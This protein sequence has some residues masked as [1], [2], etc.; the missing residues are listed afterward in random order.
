MTL[1]LTQDY[2]FWSKVESTARSLAVL[3]VLA[4]DMAE[5][6]KAIATHDV[7]RVLIDL[8]HPDYLPLIQLC[9]QKKIHS[10]GFVSHMDSETIAAARAAGCT[11]V[12]PKSQFSA[13]LAKILVG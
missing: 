13:Q 11:T 5:A 10:L 8:R 2:F 4:K 7:A 6:E 3:A 12:I 9:A 1:L